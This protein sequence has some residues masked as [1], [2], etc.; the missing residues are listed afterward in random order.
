[1]GG[2]QNHA[3]STAHASEFQRLGNIL[4]SAQSP[5]LQNGLLRQMKNISL[6]CLAKR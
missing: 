1:M 3:I 6:M 4:P 5:K 2:D